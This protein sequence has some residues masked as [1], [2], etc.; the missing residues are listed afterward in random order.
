[1]LVLA[2]Q[3]WWKDNH[4]MR[5]KGIVLTG[6]MGVGKSTVGPEVAG[7]L[8]VSY[9][10]T[11]QWMEE[12]QGLDVPHLVKTD[13]TEFR[14]QEA[15]ALE[16]ILDQEP[17]V[18]STGGGIVSTEIGRNALKASSAS[19]VWLKAPFEVSADRI[20]SD[21]GR[22][23]PLFNDLE[24]ARALFDERQQ[25]YEETADFHV[26]ATLGKSMLATEIIQVTT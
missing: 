5:N 4:L 24:S 18:V 3:V 25:W 23:R 8:K 2:N 21:S 20:Q 17:G 11:D 15:W 7:R 19:I 16:A 6:F 10:D 14:R 9:F 22:E 1:M 26:D 13:M 12:E